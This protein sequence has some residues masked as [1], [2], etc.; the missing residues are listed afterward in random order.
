MAWL[1]E[2]NVCPGLFYGTSA[3]DGYL[4]RIRTPGGF[5]NAQQG[6][7]LATL[8]E[9]WGSHL[10]QVTNRA[11]LQIRAVQGAPTAELLQTLQT[12]GLAAENPR[13][14]HL[15]NVM[16]SPTAGIDADELMDTRPLVTALD[17]YIQHH[18]E[19]VGLPA[20]FSLGID[21]GGAVGIGTRSAI[22]WEHRYNEIQ[23]SAVVGSSQEVSFQLYLGADK[24]LWD[25]QMLI[26]PDE[27]VP[28]VGA[29]VK[30]YL[31]YVNQRGGMPK[32]PRMKHLLQDWGGVGYL[33][34]VNEYLT[35][36]LDPVRDEVPWRPTQPYAHLGVHA[37]RQQGF[38]YIGIHLR[39]GQL[40]STQLQGLAELSQTFGSQQLR[41]TPWQTILLPDIREEAVAEVLQHLAGL[42]LGV[43]E[44]RVAAAIAA[45]AG[46]PGCA[47]AVTATQRDAIALQDYLNQHLTLERPVNIHFTACPKSCAQ[48]SPA[49]ITLLGTTIEQSGQT[50]EGYHIYV[51][52]VDSNS[53][54]GVFA[55]ESQPMN[56][57]HYLGEVTTPELPSRIAQLLGFYQQ[58][59][60]TAD[61]LFPAFTHRFS[62]NKLQELM[63]NPVLKGRT[64]GG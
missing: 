56:H 8:A 41:L 22:S 42:G 44:N 43:S 10:I 27:C 51:G 25:T 49:E 37:Q 40:T 26:P 34:G 28:V 19:L 64:C 54:L 20:K 7:V 36:P 47:S 38:C 61:E 50:L 17:A 1:M 45:C 29:L 62:I 58:Y 11:N 12:L 16:T 15:R 59:R 33:Q 35:H 23:L 2:P 57:Q 14:D 18:P 63:G 5:L 3:Q 21:G 32:K 9:S 60:T 31:D 55:L 39:L 30:V 24:Q 53:D 6:R 48:P 4:I 46:K 52:R 13:L